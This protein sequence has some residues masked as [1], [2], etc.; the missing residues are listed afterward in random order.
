[1]L[2]TLFL[3]DFYYVGGGLG[4]GTGDGVSSC[5]RYDPRMDKWSE[6]NEHGGE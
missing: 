6:I 2:H 1:M 4:T 5:S 3:L